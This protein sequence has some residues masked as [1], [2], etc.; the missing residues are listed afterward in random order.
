MGEGEGEV[1]SILEVRSSTGGLVRR[2]VN[3]TAV[4]GDFSVVWDG[5]DTD[6]V[7]M[8]SGVYFYQLTVGEAQ[9]TRKMSLIR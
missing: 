4:P 8:A 6:G 7:A 2:L 3:Q 9:L 1:M 5:R